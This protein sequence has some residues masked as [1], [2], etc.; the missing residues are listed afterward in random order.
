MDAYGADMR[1][2]LTQPGTVPVGDIFQGV[3]ND[4]AAAFA[5]APPAYL[6]PNDPYHLGPL[7]T[8]FVFELP[9]QI[10][11]AIQLAWTASYRCAACLLRS[12][13]C[14]HC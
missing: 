12:S 10:E 4:G 9:T 1:S 14:L 3:L 6:P 7:P 11:S 5:S 2:D 8:N 13:S